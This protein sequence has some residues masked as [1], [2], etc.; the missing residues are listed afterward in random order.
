ML[1]NLSVGVL[2]V[3]VLWGRVVVIVWLFCVL[4]GRLSIFWMWLSVFS[5]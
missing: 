1:W 3:V 4:V 5:V 2:G